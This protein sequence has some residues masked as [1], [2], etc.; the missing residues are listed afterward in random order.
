MSMVLVQ[1]LFMSMVHHQ[2]LFSCW[3]INGPKFV[4]WT[5]FVLLNF[6]IHKKFAVGKY[7]FKLVSVA[8]SICSRFYFDID[9]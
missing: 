2:R 3:I 5:K 7:L 1:L 6:Q 8:F 9:Y 4:K